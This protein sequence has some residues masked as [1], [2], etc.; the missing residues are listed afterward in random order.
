M[1]DS[2]KTGVDMVP[3]CF[4]CIIGKH[5][6]GDSAAPPV[7]AM[8]LITVTFK[9]YE[10]SLS[11]LKSQ[12]DKA[13]AEQT[14]WINEAKQV[15]KEIE[16]RKEAMVQA[17]QTWITATMDDV[18]KLN[19]DLRNISDLTKLAN[20]PQS[21]EALEPF[22]QSMQDTS[23]KL[24]Q[25]IKA[26][27][28][29]IQRANVVLNSLA[30]GLDCLLNADDD[31]EGKDGNAVAGTDNGGGDW[32]CGPSFEK[33]ATPGAVESS[34]SQSDSVCCLLY[35]LEGSPCGGLGGSLEMLGSVNAPASPSIRI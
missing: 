26:R 22:E 33:E 34:A 3:Y 30:I 16:E 21:L 32:F 7:K 23:I 14:E 2:T 10:T 28:R 18:E 8:E 25:L 11:N 1:I 20:V 12:V 6:A 5:A 19:N 35:L 27:C 17:S 15:A 9:R 29:T 13:S 24:G 31:L 4:R